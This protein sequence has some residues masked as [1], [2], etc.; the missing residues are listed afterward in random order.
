M[1]RMRWVALAASVMTSVVLP[2]GANARVVYVP[3]TFQIAFEQ[4]G[5]PATSCSVSVPRGSNAAT[6]LRAASRQ[7][8]CFVVNYQL[9]YDELYRK[10]HVRCIDSLCEDFVYDSFWFQGAPAAPPGWSEP[11]GRYV[12]DFHASKGAVLVYTYYTRPCAFTPGS[13]VCV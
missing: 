13:Y 1:G 3:V 8:A 10:H 4:A 2:A 5:H 9:G 12:E 11:Y 6:V 7:Q